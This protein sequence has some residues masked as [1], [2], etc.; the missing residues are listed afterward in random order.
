MKCNL[1]GSVEFRDVGQRENAMCKTCGSYERTRLMQL[2]IKRHGLRR[3]M[4]VL[5]FAPERGLHDWLRSQIDDYVTADFDLDRYAHIPGIQHVDLTDPASYGRFGSFDLIVHNHVIEHIPY[6]Y[7]A[8]LLGLH[9]MLRPKGV[10]AFSVP[11]YGAFYT[12]HFGPLT[13]EEAT[14]R[15]GQFD[16]IRRF[17]P[18]DID[19]TIG[20]LFRLGDS[21]LIADFGAE[22]LQ[23]I[24][25][26]ETSWLGWHGHSV[27]WLA[28]SDC[29]F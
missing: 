9:R 20:A 10:Q 24:N 2:Y 11:I 4:R 26:P 5:H 7:S 22:V 19:R 18:K 14:Q 12:E 6:N 1:C 8:L 25:F 3:D 23:G 17:S 28:D 29:R 13:P 21:D 16:H 27:F 15:F